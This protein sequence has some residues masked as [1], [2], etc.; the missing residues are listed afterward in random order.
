MRVARILL[1]V[2]STWAVACS[3]SGDD[4]DSTGSSS[5]GG[6]GSSSSSGGSSGGTSS[7]GGASSSGSPDGGSG[8]VCTTPTAVLC[9]DQVVAELNLKATVN[10]DLVEN[11]QADGGVFITHV[12]ATAGGFNNPTPPSYVYAAFTDTGL[13]K[14]DLS[15]EAALLSMDWDI[16]FR[17]YV[18]RINSGYSGPSCVNAA[19]MPDATEFD[20]FTTVPANAIW[21]TDAYFDA[22]CV[23]ISD[24]TGL[25]SSPAAALASYY[26]YPGCVKMTGNVFVVRRADG[27]MVKLEVLNYYNDAAQN[28]CQT[29]DAVTVMPTGSGNIRLQWAFLD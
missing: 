9:E 24:G 11:T 19:R 17:R 26:S 14:R 27:R 15:D 8:A 5:S 13:I 2:M 12:D 25:T 6:T 18:I 7:S 10:P 23:F 29:T 1:A 22:S 16:A 4:D 21:R 28:E 3:N 20:T